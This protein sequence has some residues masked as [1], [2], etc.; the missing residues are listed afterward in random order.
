MKELTLEEVRKKLKYHGSK[1][2]EF[3]KKEQQLICSSYNYE[4]S[5]IHYPEYGYMYVTWQT[6]DEDRVL[7]QGIAFYSEKT[8]YR[9]ACFINFDALREWRIPMQT[10]KEDSENGNIKIITSQEFNIALR[11]AFDGFLDLALEQIVDTAGTK[12]RNE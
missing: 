5:Y 7:L 4:K 1:L 9:D 2:R 10:F 12:V 11:E 6:T 8:M 3:R